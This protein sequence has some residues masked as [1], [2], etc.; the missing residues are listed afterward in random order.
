MTPEALPTPYDIT[1]L[2]G[3]PF[4]PSLWVWA[5][6]LLISL[7]LLAITAGVPRRKRDLP[8]RPAFNEALAALASIEKADV[9]PRERLASSS[10]A[11]RRFLTTLGGEDFRSRTAT[12][13]CSGAGL[14]AAIRPVLE[15]TAEIEAARFNPALTSHEAYDLARRLA[16]ALRATS[17]DY[18]SPGGKQ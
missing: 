13:L 8:N 5:A 15:V 16:E 18:S 12:E 6:L 17:R 3:L 7:I 4:V 2:P 14:P 1:P 9:L 11:A 10:L